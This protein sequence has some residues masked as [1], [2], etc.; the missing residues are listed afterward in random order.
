MEFS[1]KSLKWWI[2]YFQFLIIEIQCDLTIIIIKEYSF[3][4]IRP[5]FVD[6]FLFQS[7]TKFFEF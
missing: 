2:N 6:S 7:L 1:S 4:I 3:N 5:T